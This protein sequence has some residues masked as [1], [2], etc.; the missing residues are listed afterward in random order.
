[1]SALIEATLRLSVVLL[2]AII[3]CLLLKS[4][5]A[6]LRH[7]VLAVAVACAWATPFLSNVLPALPAAAWATWGGREAPHQD[8]SQTRGRVIE[9]R[10]DGQVFAEFSLAAVSAAA[11][12]S[13]KATPLVRGVWLA[14]TLL[15]GLILLV[16]LGRLRW[17][18]SRAREIDRGPWF[19]VGHELRDTYRISSPVR[20]LQSTHPALLVTWGWRRPKIMLPAAAQEWTTDRIRI[21]LAHELA[22]VARGDWAVQLAAETLRSALWFNPL[23]WM[24]CRR[25]R[26]ESELACDDEVLARGVEGHEYATHL[27]ALA[28]SLNPGRRSWVAA[29]AMARPSSLEG[30]VRAML[31]TVTNRRSVSTPARVLTTATLLALTILAAGLFAQ[32]RFY[33][34][35]GTAFD[36]TNRLL[37]GT[38]V[39]LTNTSSK[40]KYEVQTD[41]TGKFEFVGLPPAQYKLETSLAGFAAL[42]EEIRISGNTQRDLRLKV[43]SL[44]ETVT[45]T[46]GSVDVDVS[47]RLDPAVK[48]RRT[49]AQLKFAEFAAQAKAKC[50]AGAPGPVGGNILPPAKLLDVKPIYPEH[51]RL[52]KIGGV[53]QMEAVI[54]TDGTVRNVPVVNGPHPEL[55]SAAVDAVRQW[56]FSTTLLNCEPIPVNM[57]V[58]VMFAS[59]Q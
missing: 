8:L 2:P 34:F 25:L 11:D 15:S 21:V 35:T 56:R 37:P 17:L 49:Q 31:N 3:A 9:P 32:T 45:V 42:S 6:A 18:A 13:P 12:A 27:L 28:R 29:P 33:S 41:A 19:D 10:Q 4:R 20:L 26:I 59:A 24:T 5:S 1:V 36:P 57:K 52:A 40:A 47:V 54:G 43:G 46:D 39:I 50:A 44:Q 58:S 14:G 16:G 38:T 48:I 22:H 30:R 7:W 51:L 55:E 53:V 23:L